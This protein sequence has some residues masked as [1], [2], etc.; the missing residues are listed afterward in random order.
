LRIITIVNFINYTLFRGTT[1]HRGL[2]FF[3]RSPCICLT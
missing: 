1:N 2:K 3:Y